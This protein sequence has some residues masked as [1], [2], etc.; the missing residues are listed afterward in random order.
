MKL[1]LLLFIST[2]VLGEVIDLGTIDSRSILLDQRFTL[3]TT[4][5]DKQGALTGYLR[6]KE[7]DLFRSL[8]RA[9]EENLTDP[10]KEWKKLLDGNI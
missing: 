1:L 9:N 5:S 6:S 4:E 10:D 8:D 2:S 7:L 3:R